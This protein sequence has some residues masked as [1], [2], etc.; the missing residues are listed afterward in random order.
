MVCGL[1]MDKKEQS[2]QEKDI[3]NLAFL[4]EFLGVNGISVAQAAE[5]LG[6]TR[7]A[8]LK[9]FRNDDAYLSKVEQLVETC[10]Y[11]LV[12]SLDKPE[13][14]S[15]VRVSIENAGSENRRLAFLDRAL[16]SAGLSKTAASRLIGMSESS[17]G[18]W[19]RTDDCEISHLVDLAK[20]AGLIL[21]INFKKL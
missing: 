6:Y 8:I 20:A 11:K 7:H 3:K 1:N 5:K 21:N 9:W 15:P 18:Y 10:G 12:L 2:I 16:I 4:Q 13:S 19:L 17:V 14:N